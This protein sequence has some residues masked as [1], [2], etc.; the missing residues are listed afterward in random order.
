MTGPR[1]IGNGLISSSE[2]LVV[3]LLRGGLEASFTVGLGLSLI[4]RDLVIRRFVVPSSLLAPVEE[5]LLSLTG[6]LLDFPMSARD[7]SCTCLLARS[8]FP[9][10]RASRGDASAHLCR[11]IGTLLNQSFQ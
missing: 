9:R 2:S 6:F 11:E 4:C 8:S 1:L 10:I 3:A 5:L 7:V